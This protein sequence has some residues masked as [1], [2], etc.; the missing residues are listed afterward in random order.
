M[1]KLNFGTAGIPLAAKGSDTAAG[2]SEVRTL[3]LSAMEL[4]FVR[5]INITKEKAP[6]VRESS[7]VNKIVLTCHAPYFINL[8]S[9]DKGIV[10]AS[11]ERILGSARIASM[12]GCYS[13]CFHAG[14][15]MKEPNEKVYG[16]IKG[17]IKKITSKLNDEGINLWVRPETTG[18][19]TQFGDINELVRLSSEVENVLPCI[20]FAHLHARSAGKFNSRKEF[21]SVLSQVEKDLGR[22]ALSSMHIHMAGIN[23]SA[24]GERNHMNLK[25]S[26]FNYIDLMRELKDFNAKGVLI[27]ESPN[28]EE[29]AILMKKAYDAA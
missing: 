11:I 9:A 16:A 14:F 1:D 24:K 3:G 8:N 23:Y 18:K 4:E 29:D 2:I 26:D 13:V 15:Y 25:D 17:N 5:D 10:R 6:L 19:A 27:S 22:E 7:E 21:S 12:C 28:I 20:D